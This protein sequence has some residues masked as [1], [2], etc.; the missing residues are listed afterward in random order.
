MKKIFML[1]VLMHL[2][3]EEGLSYPDSEV[4]KLLFRGFER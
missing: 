4:G 3:I 1:M 2:M